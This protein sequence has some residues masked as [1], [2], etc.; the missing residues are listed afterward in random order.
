MNWLNALKLYR[1]GERSCIITYIGF[2]LQME[3]R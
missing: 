3:Y 2:R 1:E